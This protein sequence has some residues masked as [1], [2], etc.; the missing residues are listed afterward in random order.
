M[1]S[2]TLSNSLLRDL[3]RLY[4]DAD[5]YDVIIQVGEESDIEDFKAHS[6]I[7]RIRSTYFNAA[8][9]SNWVKK[10]GNVIIFKKPNIKPYVFKIIL[11]YIYTGIVILDTNISEKNLIELII[12][13]DE[14]NLDELID[15][16]QKYFITLIH[17]L[18][19]KRIIKLFNE[20]SYH[21][22]IINTLYEYIKELIS[23]DT[24]RFFDNNNNSS[25]SNNNNNLFLELEDNSLLSLIESDHFQMEEI[26]IWNNLLKWAIKKNSKINNDT[27]FWKD[28]EIEIIKETI[29]QFIPHVRFFQISSKDY[30]NKIY[31]LSSLLPKKL[32]KDINLYFN[33]SKN[34]SLLSSKILP[35]RINVNS[36]IIK[37]D[38]IYQIAHWIDKKQGK[39]SLSSKELQYDF[40]LLLRGSRDGFDVEHF[41]E[42]CYNKGA[43]LVLIK[44]KDDDKIIGG[45]NPI[46]WS[47][48]SVYLST[49][50]SFIFSFNYN[51]NPSTTILS[52]VRNKINAIYD[53]TYNNHGFGGYDLRIFK[54]TCICE[55]YEM[56][57]IETNSF[58]IEDYEVFQIIKKNRLLELDDL[59]DHF[60]RN[61]WEFY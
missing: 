3:N 24:K 35:P 14:I 47:G 1:S 52:R 33:V 42:Q 9:S 61:G 10:D 6:N 46:N 59:S 29:Y 53:S 40:K 16:I 34:S 30:Y 21:Q 11:K 60:A 49:N 38:H 18:P 27:S 44:L 41:K 26:K 20:L 12:A 56:N 13:A 8:L 57:I 28:K 22:G 31:P 23:S 7:L 17:E 36:G 2:E 32:E 37:M 48:S 50:D 15:Y 45:Y 5:D 4:N 55:N 43:T 39:F 51:L 58:K 25:S 54:K 19:E